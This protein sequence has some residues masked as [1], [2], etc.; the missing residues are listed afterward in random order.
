MENQPSILYRP[1]T[2][3]AQSDP[4][5]APGDRRIAAA[6]RIDFRLP[7]VIGVTGHRDLQPQ[8]HAAIAG[9]VR[10]VLLHFKTSYPNTPLVLLSPLAEGADRLVAEVALESGIGARLMAPLPMVREI[11]EHDFKSADSR[12]E[13]GRLLDAAEHKL[14]LPTR[15][16]VGRDELQN[17]LSAR[18]GQYAAVGEF[19]ARNSQVLIALWDGKPGEHGGTAEVVSMK[20]SGVAPGNADSLPS[21]HRGPVFHITVPR[22]RDG[23]RN[24]EVGCTPLFPDSEDYEPS[25]GHTFYHYRVF[26]AL[27]D[28]NREVVTRADEE[29][30]AA[31]RAS[32]DLL[33]NPKSLP[34]GK[35]GAEIEVMRQH[36]AMAD[37]LADRY[38]VATNRTLYRLSLVVFAAALSFDLAVHILVNPRVRWLEAVCLFGLP[39]LTGVAML[40]HRRARRQDCQNRYQDYRG[41]AEGLRIQFFWRLAGVDECV[42]DH[43]LG[44]HRYEMQWIRDACR[45]SLVAANCPLGSAG[46]E[47]KKAT[48][49]GWIDSQRN[50]FERAAGAQERKLTRMEQ[51]IQFCFWMGLT[52]VLVMGAWVAML[53]LKRSFNPAFLAEIHEAPELVHGAL[54]LAITMSAVV[55]ALTHNYVEKLALTTQVRM[56]ARMCRL[57]RHNAEKLRAAQGEEFAR[58]L[59]SLGREALVEN[60]EWVMHHRERPL[61]VPHH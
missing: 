39:L 61:E 51:R 11:Y 23:S 47:V 60:G 3:A 41:L 50:Y 31:E 40:I 28:Y 45:S 26:K 43:Y 6:A 33:P 42:A 19:I 58:G 16:G 2:A 59:F 22:L 48:F 35:I 30:A 14:E 56:Y 12:A 4:A 46:D 9:Q 25:E 34:A 13:F 15:P 24:I 52:I 8:A 32:R 29:S 5:A 55:A 44:R 53:A 27:D 37:A 17:Q 21:V 1:R 38:G 20:L 7:L 36:Y 10:E 49:E 18:Q 54:L 57:Y